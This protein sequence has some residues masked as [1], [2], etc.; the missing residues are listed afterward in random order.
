M[1]AKNACMHL[2]SLSSC[3]EAL[4]EVQHEL[5]SYGYLVKYL[6]PEGENGGEL[7]GLGLSLERLA[8]TVALAAERLGEL[9]SK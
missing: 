5:C 4:W 8:R 9:D 6:S 7:F 2:K 1:S 3:E